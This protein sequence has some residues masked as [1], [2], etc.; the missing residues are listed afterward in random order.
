MMQPRFSSNLH[1]AYPEPKRANLV[2]L[3]AD[4]LRK[5]YGNVEAVAG[6]SFD[7]HAGE[8]FGLLGPNGAG[9]TTT[10]S[11]LATRQRP[12]A[13]DATLLGNSIVKE[14]SIVRSLIGVAPQEIALYPTLT[15][16]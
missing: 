13:G 9:K 10:V 8:I 7:L 4:K 12:S 1:E 16:A 15:A 11:M 14:P 3:R 2:V 6:V 5:R